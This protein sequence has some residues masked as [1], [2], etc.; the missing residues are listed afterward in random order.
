MEGIK[1]IITLLRDLAS[2]LW[3]T[4]RPRSELAAEN[5][6]LRKQ[7]A[8]FQERKAKPHRPDTPIRITLVLL[9]YFQLA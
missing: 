8:M 4:L 2:F 6:F 1:M 7:L 5:R 3:L 9:G